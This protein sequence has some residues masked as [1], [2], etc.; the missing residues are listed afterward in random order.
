MHG[1]KPHLSHS[2][3]H[4]CAI[5]T[6]YNCMQL[7]RVQFLVLIIF[8]FLLYSLSLY[9]LV[10][11]HW[12]EDLCNSRHLFISLLDFSSWV[13]CGYFKFAK[14]KTKFIICSLTFSHIPTFLNSSLSSWWGMWYAQSCP[15]P[16]GPID[17]SPSGSSVHGFFQA[18]ILEWVAIFSSKGSS[19]P[20]DQCR[21]F[22]YVSCIGRQILYH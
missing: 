10:D 9:N 11:F 22:S 6:L 12:I 15:S 4:P 19:Q 2:A 1:F 20:R 7:H 5:N 21:D 18:R 3:W 16:C 13:S 14:A 8:F 17:C